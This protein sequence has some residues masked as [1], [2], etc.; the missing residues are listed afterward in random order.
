MAEQAQEWDQ[1][2]FYYR[3]AI[4]FDRENP[5]YHYNLG[6]IYEI[7][8]EWQTAAG[9]YEKAVRLKS[10]HVD[11]LVA[12][13]E[14][15]SVIFDDRKTALKYYEKAIENAG[16]PTTHEKIAKRIQMLQGN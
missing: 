6:I 15:N 9:E 11:A 12:L 14:L 10:D 4:E 1:A 5:D 16:D 3:K 2:I 13:A 7:K 8:G